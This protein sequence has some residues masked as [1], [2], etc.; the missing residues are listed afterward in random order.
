METIT[1][2]AQICLNGHIITD[3]SR[4]KELVRNKHCATCGEETVMT[5]LSCNNSIPVRITYTNI[6]GIGQDYNKPN[7]CSS[8]G[9]AYPWTLRRT[10]AAKKLILLSERLSDSEKKE[11][12]DIVSDLVTFTPNTS[13]AQATF[14][15]YFDK[16]ER[17]IFKRVCESML[18]LLPNKRNEGTLSTQIQNAFRSFS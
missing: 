5:C 14:I 2:I 1:G 18:C 16:I 3:S 7:Y 8:C 11:L 10:E 15:K 6:H 13:V 9:K 17:N 4:S 12:N